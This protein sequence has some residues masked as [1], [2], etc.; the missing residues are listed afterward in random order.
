M[1][2][3]ASTGPCGGNP[4]RTPQF[5][6]ISRSTSSPGMMI[7]STRPPSV[8]LNAP[9]VVTYQTS[10]PALSASRPL[11]VTYDSLS[12]SF[13]WPAASSTMCPSSIRHFAP[14]MKVP[15]KIQVRALA[16]M[17]G[18]PPGPT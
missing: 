17:L 14:C 10:L 2:E 4:N 1:D 7:S 15:T 18:R 8:S 6:R 13:G 12:I 16:V 11:K 5:G 9:T 3:G